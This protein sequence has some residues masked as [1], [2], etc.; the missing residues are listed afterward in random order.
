MSC[1]C[2]WKKKKNLI[3]IA[4]HVPVD[5]QMKSTTKYV[6]STYHNRKGREMLL[7]TENETTT[8]KKLF[9]QIPES[10]MAFLFSY[11]N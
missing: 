3:E 1:E 10:G 11:R 2:D 6:D 8:T 4:P 9:W 5:L 7:K